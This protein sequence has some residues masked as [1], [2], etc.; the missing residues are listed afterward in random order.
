VAAEPKLVDLMLTDAA[1]E[2]ILMSRL[3]ARAAAGRM[4]GMT[5]VFINTMKGEPPVW[6]AL[7][8]LAR[9]D[10]PWYDGVQHSCRW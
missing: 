9:L 1:M 7:P 2:A 3:Q 4:P 8:L 10:S 5:G 6:S